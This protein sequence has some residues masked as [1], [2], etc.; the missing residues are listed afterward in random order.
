VQQCSSHSA[1]LCLCSGDTGYLTDGSTAEHVLYRLVTVHVGIDFV[2]SKEGFQRG[3][4]ACKLSNIYLDAHFA[5][6]TF[7]LPLAR[8]HGVLYPPAGLAPGT[9]SREPDMDL[10]PC[11]SSFRRYFF[12]LSYFCPPQVTTGCTQVKASPRG[13]P[14]WHSLQFNLSSVFFWHMPM[15]QAATCLGHSIACVS[16]FISSRTLLLRISRWGY[17]VQVTRVTHTNSLLPLKGLAFKTKSCV[18][19]SAIYCP[20]RGALTVSLCVTYR[21]SERNPCSGLPLPV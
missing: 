20:K 9:P 4:P 15:L 6:S 3:R 12:C 5:D 10:Q 7:S 17:I 21:V 16:A 1:A 11:I 18:L 13:S 8:I 2:P 19:N 14:D